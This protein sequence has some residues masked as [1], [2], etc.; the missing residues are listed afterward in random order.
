MIADE[1][2]LIPG[3]AIVGNEVFGIGSGPGVL[4]NAPKENSVALVL[5]L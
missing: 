5:L 3:S 4:D 1:E 2:D